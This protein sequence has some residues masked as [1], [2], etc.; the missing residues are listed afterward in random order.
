MAEIRVIE[1]YSPE[2]TSAL[3]RELG[4]NDVDK[5]VEEVTDSEK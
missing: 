2:E 5:L 1:S 3:G 4:E